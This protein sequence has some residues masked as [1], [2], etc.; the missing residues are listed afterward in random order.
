MWAFLVQNLLKIG[1]TAFTAM[2][3]KEMME[4]GIFYVADKWTK[5]T[6]T[7]VDDEWLNKFKESY[8]QVK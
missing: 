1:V 2:A 8:K 4:W 5:S 7:T 3:G 6:K